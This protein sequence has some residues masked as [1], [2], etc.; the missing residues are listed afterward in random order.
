MN[1]SNFPN[2]TTF[3]ALNPGMLLG[4][5]VDEMYDSGLL[6]KDLCDIINL[7]YDKSIQNVLSMQKTA[8]TTFEGSETIYKHVDDVWT[9]VLKDV[10]IKGTGL[11]SFVPILKIIALDGRVKDCGK[12][13]RKRKASQR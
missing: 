10:T 5:V 4:E 1:P 6:S 11:P 3:R 13:I 12:R 2:Y 9:F 8:T 7:Q